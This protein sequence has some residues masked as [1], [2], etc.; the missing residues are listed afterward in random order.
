MSVGC[1]F[2]LGEPLLDKDMPF[3]VE[4]AELGYDLG[5]V[6]EEESPWLESRS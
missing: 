4:R 2:P 1:C 6:N 5:I 3:A